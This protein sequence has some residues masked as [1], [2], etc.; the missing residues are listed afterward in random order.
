[1][2]DERAM[3]VYSARPT[4]LA[5]AKRRQAP[6]C[7]LNNKTAAKVMEQLKIFIS[8]ASEDRAQAREIHQRLMAQGYQPWLDDEDLLAGQDFKLIIE[9][10]LTCSDFVIICLSQ[11]S[12]SKRGFIQR[13]IKYALDKLQEMLP[14]DIFV[15]PARLDD[16]ALPDELKNR[17]WVNLFEERGWEKLFKALETEASRRDMPVGK[18][19]KTSKATTLLRLA[20]TTPAPIE[21]RFTI[22]STRPVRQKLKSILP[23]LVLALITIAGS[24]LIAYGVYPLVVRDEALGDVE[25]RA[26][27]MTQHSARPNLPPE[28]TEKNSGLNLVMKLIARGSFMMGSDE[29]E[30]SRSD[31]LEVAR[32]RADLEVIRNRADNEGPQHL[33]TISDYYIGMCE[34]TQAQWRIVMP[35]NPA[36]FTGDFQR[37][38][39]NVSWFEA[40]QFCSQ[41]NALTGKTYSLPS[42]AEWEYAARAKTKEEDVSNFGAMGWYQEN[43]DGKTHPVGQKKANNYG[44][45]DMNGNVWEWCEDVWHDRYGERHGAPPTDGSPWISGG[46]SKYRVMR[47]GAWF[48]FSYDC[49]AAVRHRA[50]PGQHQ[51]SYGFRLVLRPSLLVTN[52]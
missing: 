30:I 4:Q 44:L 28:F 19:S 50:L 41:L 46:D 15:I 23:G 43:A 34:I 31:G 12:V 29:L 16:C 5:A 40:Q 26:A 51:N 3:L 49:R 9:R 45:H 14:E 24:V 36:H 2:L 52:F 6:D 13:E 37:P 21:A 48:S 7:N 35:N 32:F 22:A 25:P 10:S 39:E 47:G 1:M 38:V 42:E 27:T 17:H 18:S 8:Y 20:S 11:T 33:V